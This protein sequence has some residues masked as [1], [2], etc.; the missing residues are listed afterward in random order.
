MSINTYNELKSAILDQLKGAGLEEHIEAFISATEDRLVKDLKGNAR[1]S[2]KGKDKTDTL[3]ATAKVGSVLL[4]R[5][6]LN[7]RSVRVQ[8]DKSTRLK[9]LSPWELVD[10][11]EDSGPGTPSVYSLL[12][13][14]LK[15]RP[16]PD[17]NY[18][19]EVTYKGP[20]LRL[21]DK[22]PSNSL[23]TEH[24]D[25]YLYGSLAHAIPLIGIDGRGEVW[26]AKYIEALDKLNEGV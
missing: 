8:S 20:G 24:P 7:V 14:A 17:K 3:I 11:Y 25:L 26:V 22:T 4:S 2:L 18:R 13:M 19:I 16:V 12:G 6:M 23:L 1:F 15:L 9:A 10:R 5:D 21:S